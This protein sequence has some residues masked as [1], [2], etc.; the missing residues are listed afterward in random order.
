M[1]RFLPLLFLFLFLCPRVNAQTSS[2]STTS[3]PTAGASGPGCVVFP[4]AGQGSIGIQVTGTFSGTITFSGSIDRA[5]FVTLPMTPSAGGPGVTTTT[6]TGVWSAPVAGYAIVQVAFTSYVSGTAV[7]SSVVSGAKL[8]PLPPTKTICSTLAGTC[9]CTT[10]V[11]AGVINQWNVITCLLPAA[12]LVA[13]GDNVDVHV[14]AQLATNANTKGYQLYWNGGTCSGTGGSCCASGTQV[15]S[16]G[17]SGT[18]VTTISDY[19][20][21]RTSSSNQVLNGIT[22]TGG[23]SISS[24]DQVTSTATDTGT[25]LVAYC[26]RNTAAGAATLQ[27]PNPAITIVRNGQ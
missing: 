27:A 2:I 26:A 11:D 16:D 6:T 24:I 8:A 20:V 10:Y 18:N 19:L 5:N 23:S 14:T 7:V 13:N 25:I 21:T 4:A 9:G 15:F 17:S 22:Y 1:R 3:C 12:T